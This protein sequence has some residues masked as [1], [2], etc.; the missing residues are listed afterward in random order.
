M[1]S[2]SST[3][4]KKKIAI[5]APF[6]TGTWA[7][8]KAINESEDFEG[9]QLH[10]YSA[11]DQ[12][13]YPLSEFSGVINIRRS[14]PERYW[15]GFFE[16]IDQPA[17][18][19]F[20]GTKEKV[21]ATPIE[22]LVNHYKKFDWETYGWLNNEHFDFVL[23]DLFDIHSVPD[24]MGISLFRSSGT[25][26]R[27]LGRTIPVALMWTEDLN[28]WSETLADFFG[29]QGMGQIEKHHSGDEKWYAAKY[30]LFKEEIVKSS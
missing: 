9:V 30:R 25:S 4:T 7:V 11:E 16:D 23:A 22:E 29:I 12:A 28:L 20:F 2:T 27:P 19:Y 6:K 24:R 26:D 13:K 5:I 15:S 14:A 1:T 17:Y 18:P 21:L 8:R 3:S 10:S